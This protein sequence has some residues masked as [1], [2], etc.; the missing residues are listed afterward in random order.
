MLINPSTLY[1]G[2]NVKVDST[3][4]LKMAMQQKAKK[5]ALDE[6]S[7]QYF[8]KLPEKLNTA[9]VRMQDMADPNGNGG[10]QKDIEDWQGKWFRNKDAIKKGGMAQQE[11][12]ADFSKIRQRIE[13]SKNRAK[14]ELTVGKEALKPNGWKPRNNDHPIIDAW[15]RSIYDGSSKKDDG[16]SEY[17]LNDLSLSAAPYTPDYELK[18]NKVITANVEPEKLPNEKGVYDPVTN[19]VTYTYGYTPEKI[20]QIAQNAVATIASDRTLYNHYEDLL[21]KPDM[22][23]AASKALQAD[24]DKTHSD[25]LKVVVDTPEEMAAG[26]K[27]AQF[28]NARIP[29]VFTDQQHI[30]EFKRN[31]RLARQAFSEK[32]FNKREA[33]KNNRLALMTQYNI[34]SVYDKV[35]DKETLQLPDPVGGVIKLK[36]A[37]DLTVQEQEDLFGKPDK[38]GQYP[39]PPVKL[40]EKIYVKVGDDGQLMDANNAKIDADAAFAKTFTR[41]RSSKEAQAKGKVQ[42]G[43]SKPQT[44][45]A[46]FD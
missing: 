34:P 8:N 18:H 14:K 4:F 37:S 23:E 29:K 38:Y 20:K 42:T 22:V 12:M 21:D 39:N 9:G 24:Y 15:S 41:L 13:E 45:K 1:S 25:G 33:G 5:Q 3:P 11:F 36:D 26:L 35:D 6:A 31:E 32:M 28:A 40:N 2:G 27:M 43:S 10:I 16:V 46:K 44:K 17:E 7:N 19:K 30:E